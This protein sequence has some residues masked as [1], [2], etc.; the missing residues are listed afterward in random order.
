MVDSDIKNRQRIAVIG[1][2]KATAEIL[3]MAKECGRLIAKNNAILV[4]GGLGGVMEAA[5]MGAKEA[6]GL[7][8]GVLPGRDK[9]RANKYIDFAIL[10]GLGEIR[11]ALVIM[12]ADSVIAIDGSYGTLNEI[13]HALISKKPLFA[14]KS[15][16]IAQGEGERKRGELIHCETVEEAV[17][18]AVLAGTKDG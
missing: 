13:S 4:T 10:T 3:E 2:S 12:N 15:W 8:V 18:K 9:D 1:G 17:K 6:G 16:H 5:S 14:V 11:N 7:T